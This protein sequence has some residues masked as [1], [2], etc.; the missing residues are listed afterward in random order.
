M[1]YYIKRSDN[2]IEIINLYDVHELDN[3]SIAINK[4]FLYYSELINRQKYDGTK[5]PTPNGIQNQGQVKLLLSELF[6]YSLINLNS[7]KNVTVIYA[8]CSPY[9]HGVKLM[10]FYKNNKSL[11]WVYIDPRQIDS[12]ILKYKNV[13]FIKQYLTKD[14]CKLLVK[15]Y[16]NIVFLSDIRD[17]SNQVV[18]SGDILHDQDLTIEC[19]KILKPIY[20][21]LKF[22][23]PFPDSYIPI[24]MPTEYQLF[25]Q[26]FAKSASIETRMIIKGDTKFKKST[27]QD[28]LEYEEKLCYYNNHIKR[29]RVS[30]NYLYT[31]MKGWHC[32]CYDCVCMFYIFKMVK[33]ANQLTISELNLAKFFLDNLAA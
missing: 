14:L 10:Q 7:L 1:D 4:P 2:N 16:S 31:E 17:V 24:P 11:R 13:K 21:F 6:F 33:D 12:R 15:R 32:R 20:S 9:T 28:S 18:Q 19:V 26:P 30:N 25:L 29:H 8:G 27:L 5:S 22:R 23:Y 3:T